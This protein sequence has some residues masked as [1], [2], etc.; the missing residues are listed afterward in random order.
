MSPILEEFHDRDHEHIIIPSSP[1]G[2]WITQDSLCKRDE[3]WPGRMIG[4]EANSGARPSEKK[5]GM[6]HSDSGG[7]D[8]SYQQQPPQQGGDAGKFQRHRNKEALQRLDLEDITRSL[9]LSQIREFSFVHG[10]LSLMALLKACLETGNRGH[11]S[12]VALSGY[13]EHFESRLEDDLGWGCGWRNIQML[14]SYVIAQNTECKDALFGGAGFVPDI[15]AMQQWLEIAWL[16]G[17][18]VLGADYFDWKITGTH[19]W[20]GTTECAALLR[21]FGVRARVVDFR[22]AN[23]KR[24]TDNIVSKVGGS[25][26][27]GSRLDRDRDHGDGDHMAD[28]FAHMAVSGR[29]APHSSAAGVT[30]D[31]EN[32][33][34]AAEDKAVIV[35]PDQKEELHF[36][37]QSPDD[38]NICLICVEERKHNISAAAAAAVA[39]GAGAE[40]KRGLPCGD[41]SAITGA[42]RHAYSSAGGGGGAN[43][44]DVPLNH[45]YMTDWIW[46]YFSADV[47]HSE[48][49]SNLS[50]RS[51]LY[52]QH[53]GHSR[54]IVGIERCKKDGSNKEEDYLIVLD[55]SQRTRDIVTALQR[56]QGWEELVKRGMH[57]LNQAEYQLC[58]ID[59]GIAKGEELES[60][61]TLSSVRY[62]Y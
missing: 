22:T 18:D 59:P 5:G 19:K 52:F 11:S 33:A 20:I 29:Q 54:T 56:Q 32:D 21:S 36:L 40:D 49:P 53:R 60:L 13:I 24:G 10:G 62:M 35:L 14:S 61:K 47:G 8:G 34:A 44:A 27:G 4:M 46:N 17:F 31:S 3:P 42:Q 39:S 50:S 7:V 30:E 45:K 48:R 55:P 1:E 58:Y 51:P 25:K 28:Q 37:R 16:K 41:Y 57:S 15:P 2:K 6:E 26:G 12:I 23:S 9:I 38:P 43:P